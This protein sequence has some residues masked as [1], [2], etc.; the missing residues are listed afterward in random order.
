MIFPILAAVLTVAIMATGSLATTASSLPGD[1]LSNA[2][3]HRQA[4]EIAGAAL[5]ALFAWIA[6]SQSNLRKLSGALC[7]GT[8]A[9]GVL[10]VVANAPMLHSLLAQV[11]LAGSVA[12]VAA[13]SK[14]YTDPPQMVK[15]YGWPS[16][17]SLS[18]LLPLLIGI[19]VALGAAFRHRML[20]LMPHVIGAML[21]SI[22]ILV[23]GSFVLQLCKDHKVLSGSGR[24]MMVTTFVQVFLG[25][26]IFAIRSMP[27]QDA[28]AIL[29]GASLHVITGG[30][31]L[32]VSVILG[33][34]IRRNV[35]PKS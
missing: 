18:V 24:L 15:D 22:F 4:G 16:L 20:G 5:I 3:L 33:M 29:T 34:H 25:L 35:L 10:G 13:A 23:V 6:F 21:V 31:L 26:A 17:R 30:V 12:L 2:L 14:S 32:G 11:L 8:I 28:G 1:P 27:E 19:Q 7:L 9:Q